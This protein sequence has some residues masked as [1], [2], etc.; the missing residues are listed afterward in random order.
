MSNIVYSYKDFE[1]KQSHEYLIDNS[2]LLY[3]FAPIGNYNSKLQTKISSFLVTARSVGAGVHTTSLV[4][5]EFYNKVLKD[6]FEEFKQKP[7]NVGKTSLKKDYRPSKNY[8]SD[9]SAL[10]SQ[11]KAILKICNRFPDD[12]NS[13]DIEAILKIASY[14]DFNDAYFIELAN[15]KNWIIVTRDRDILNSEM[16]KTAALS[17]LDS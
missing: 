16:R 3:P 5:S 2:V 17:F 6:F 15:R 4:L 10:T 7:E 14:I 8:K 9:V 13:V 12:F 11:V 1:P